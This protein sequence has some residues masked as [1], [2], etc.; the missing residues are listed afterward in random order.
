MTKENVELM[1][2]LGNM[3]ES[4]Q[5]EQLREML[6]RM[7]VEV[8]NTE[9]EQM[10]GASYGARSGE[11]QNQRNGY[12]PR[13][14]ETRLGSLELQ[15]PKLRSGSYFPSF[16]E[17]RR[18][19]EKA[20]VN[21]VAEAYVKGVSTRSVEDLVRAMG[22]Q[23]M[24]K[25]EVSRM[26]KSLDEDVEAFRSRPLGDRAFPYLWLDAIY[27]K[28]RENKR[29]VSRAVLVAIAVNEDGEREVIGVDIAEAEMESS[30]RAFLRGLVKRGLR[31]VQLAISDAHEG[32]R[33]AIT[34]V[35]NG[36]TWQRCYVHFIRNVMDKVPKSAQDFVKAALRTAFKQESPEAAHEAMQKAIE[37]T[38]AKWPRA[39]D[40]IREA[41]ADVL[42]YL[43]FP[44]EHHRQLRSTNPLERLN[45]EIRRRVRV[46]GIFPNRASVLRLVGMLLVEQDDEW[47]VGRRYFSTASMAQLER[48]VQLE[49]HAA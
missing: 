42:A 26:A 40:C 27:V 36:V 48:P 45:K 12:R 31:G 25:S 43:H 6:A 9:V 47:R 38:E 30:W 4:H 19:W 29:S 14:F 8:M 13:P 23:G 34:A 39:A 46:V 16:L 18:R 17:P 20:F 24:S 32:L 33:A 28:V 2:V 49:D 3:L 21:V 5:G 44:R 41:E 22:A 35:L 10:C 7:L 15:I 37:V 11:R 1:S